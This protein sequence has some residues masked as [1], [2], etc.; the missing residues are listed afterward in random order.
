MTVG[1]TNS[2]NPALSNI[3]FYKGGISTAYVQPKQAG[4]CAVSGNPNRPAT[5]NADKNAGAL[6]G[7]GIYYLA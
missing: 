7:L 1:K 4:D 5:F 6:K 3:S 2:I